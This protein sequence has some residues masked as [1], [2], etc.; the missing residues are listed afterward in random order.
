[1][2]VFVLAR[3]QKKYSIVLFVSTK[4]FTSEPESEGGAE[5]KEILQSTIVIVI[6]TLHCQE[7]KRVYVD[8]K[9]TCGRRFNNEA[10]KENDDDDDGDELI[11]THG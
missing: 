9:N 11:I 4:A 2:Y 10:K 5:E 6:H 3:V 1:M 7:K 8:L